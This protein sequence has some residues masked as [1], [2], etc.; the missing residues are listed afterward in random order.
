MN[1]MK[2][3]FAAL[4]LAASLF[5]LHLTARSADKGEEPKKDEPKTE[6]P[7]A[8]SGVSQE[9][10]DAARAALRKA[11]LDAKPEIVTKGVSRPKFKSDDVED[12]L[13]KAGFKDLKEVAESLVKFPDDKSPAVPPPPEPGKPP[14]TPGTPGT[15]APVDVPKGSKEA[16][17][18]VE[19][20]GGPDLI[21]TPEGFG[22]SATGGAGGKRVEISTATSDAVVAAFKQVSATKGNA[23]IVFTC[24]GDIDLNP[25]DKPLLKADNVTVDGRGQ[26]TLWGD[27]ISNRS[28]PLFSASGTNIIVRNIRCRNDGDNFSFGGASYPSCTRLLISHISSSGSADDGVSIG[29]GNKDVTLQWSLMAGNTRSIFLK[30]ENKGGDKREIQNISIH[31]NYITR[32]WI[33]GPLAVDVKLLDFRNNMVTNWREWGSRFDSGTTGNAVNNLHILDAWCKG[34]PD[35]TVYYKGAGPVYFAGNVGRGCKSGNDGNA[36]EALPAAPVTTL[37]VDEMEKLVSEYAGCLP[38]DAAD[39]ELM[40]IQQLAPRGKVEK[41]LRTPLTRGGAGSATA[42]PDEPAPK[43]GPDDGEAE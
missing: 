36:K 34:K 18:P 14:E 35:S 17:A 15:P 38:R 13:K 7:K 23:E 43:P 20:V 24:K 5:A 30:Y 9:V 11:G 40:T 2:P 21:W 29:Y 12:A 16:C 25:P 10:A 41:G 3:F 19:G 8:P 28:N 4:A 37:P 22:A 6:K 26:V 39:K 1:P 42:P 33:R 27:K 31:H 32:Q